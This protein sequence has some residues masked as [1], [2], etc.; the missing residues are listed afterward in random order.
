MHDFT[1]KNAVTRTALNPVG[2]IIGG[3]VAPRVNLNYHNAC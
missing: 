2:G 3:G 1:N